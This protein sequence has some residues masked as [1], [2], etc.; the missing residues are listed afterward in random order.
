VFASHAA[1][2][3]PLTTHALAGPYPSIDAAC[4]AMLD[5]EERSR[6]SA[7]S[8]PTDAEGYC[9]TSAV[10][11]GLEIRLVTISNVY[12]HLLIRSARGWFVRA[13]PFRCSDHVDAKFEPI[14]FVAQKGG[15]P[16]MLVRSTRVSTLGV[17]MRGLSICGLNKQGSPACTADLP[18]AWGE[19]T[20]SDDEQVKW[21]WT[22][23][24]VVDDA[25]HVHGAVERGRRELEKAAWRSPF[26][27]GRLCPRGEC[28]PPGR[29][30]EQRNIELEPPL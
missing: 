10:H 30:L 28:E 3:K 13:T 14:T 29:L 19:L 27:R 16:L 26:E 24:L 23:K 18:Y 8:Q 5:P 11:D 9:S 1:S 7:W 4:T 17:A 25:G 6:C 2:A 20:D 21:Q 22:I 15:R 12:A